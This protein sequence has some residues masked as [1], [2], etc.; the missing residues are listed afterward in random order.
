MI[1]GASTVGG[2]SAPGLE[3]PTRLVAVRAAGLTPDRL[4]ERLRA[5]SPPLVGRIESGRFVIDL[6]TVPARP[7]ETVLAAL[8]A[9]ERG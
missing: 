5:G 4:D 2:G 9:A 3:V 8:L 6:R 7:D 1:D